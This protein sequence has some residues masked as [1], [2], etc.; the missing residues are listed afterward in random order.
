MEEMPSSL[1]ESRREAAKAALSLA[2]GGVSVVYLLVVAFHSNQAWAIVAAIV[3]LGVYSFSAGA[4][5]GIEVA[6]RRIAPFVR[7]ILARLPALLETDEAE[8]GSPTM[9]D[10]E[11]RSVLDALQTAVAA[12]PDVFK[13]PVIAATIPAAAAVIVAIITA[14]W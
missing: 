9:T 6:V 12:R 4:L 10:V 3:M 11:R 14:L 13:S 1:F 8:G 5:L 7:K 2:F